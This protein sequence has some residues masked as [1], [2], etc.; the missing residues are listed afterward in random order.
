MFKKTIIISGAGLTLAIATSVFAQVATPVA[1]VA[2]VAVPVQPM[3][4]HVE[5]NGKVL[6][7][8]T[9]DAVSASS[10]TVKSWGG[11]WTINVPASAEVLPA[12]ATLA[13]FKVGDFVGAQGSV[14][15]SAAWTVDATLVR[16]WTERK[17]LNQEIRQNV[18]SARQEM[19]AN[20]PR[21][22]QGTVS[23]LSGQ[24]FTLTTSS[25]AS[26]SV[27]LT[28]DAKILMNNW[29][30]L[31]F[32]RVQNGDVVRVWGPVSSSTVSASIFRDTSITK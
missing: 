10:L 3:V 21:T 1:V 5:A 27:L 22:L 26:Y 6:L 11:D 12:A 8:G 24:A 13:N 9:I 2:P 16:D 20:T 25:G 19:Q 7:R 14:N 28:A 32:S 23:N 17:V 30:T 18:Q 4:L 15:Q 29:L 31:D